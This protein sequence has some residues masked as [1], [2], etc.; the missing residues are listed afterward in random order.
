LSLP[1]T[2]SGASAVPWATWPG[3]HRLP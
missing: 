3:A 2:G 1:L